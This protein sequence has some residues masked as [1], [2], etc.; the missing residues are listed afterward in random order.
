MTDT[1]Q[2]AGGAPAGTTPPAGGTPGAEHPATAPWSGSTDVWK[3]GEAGKEQPW[4]SAVPEEPVRELMKVKNY[5]NP[6]EL[7]VAYH[8]LNKLQNNSGDVI[9]FPKTDAK[10]EEIAA[11]E[12]TLYSKLGRPEAADKYE[13]KHIEGV[14]PD[15]ALTKLGKEIF[16][17]LGA[18]P[19]KAQAAMEK[20][21]KAVL[22]M[23]TSMQEQEQQANDKALTT[24]SA[25]WGAELDTNKAAGLRAV[26][27]LEAK[28]LSTETITKLESNIGAAAVVELLAVLGKG[29]AEGDGTKGGGNQNTDPNNPDTMNKE[30]AAAKIK[31]LQAD[32]AFQKKYTDK[33][34]PEHAAAL[35]L[36]EKLFAKT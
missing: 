34:H 15:E 6:G 1:G 8:N 12:K 3:V 32:D 7:A 35:A 22:A 9:A 26:K 23:H 18:S 19:A 20:W 13:F 5:K 30:Q 14:Q 36:M 28:G 4:Y 24:L 17:D 21:D 11:F 16:F 10:P 25:K 33:N 2:P 27:S 31:S 29:S